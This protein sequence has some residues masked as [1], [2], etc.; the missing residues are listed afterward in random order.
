MK[1]TLE[2]PGPLLRNTQA[3]ASSHGQYLNDFVTVALRD[4]LA[5]QGNPS[6][7]AEP[8]WMQGFG[9]PKHL[10]KETARI[11]AR[12]DACSTLGC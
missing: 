9:K 1:M 11:Q 10:H 8:R 4:K 2:F 3:A 7:A 5:A 6:S 12:L